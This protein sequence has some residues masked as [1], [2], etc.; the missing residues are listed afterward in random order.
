MHKILY[1]EIIKC[2]VVSIIN[3]LMYYSI[4]SVLFVLLSIAR[5]AAK[6]ATMKVCILLFVL[7]SSAPLKLAIMERNLYP[8]LT[9]QENTRSNICPSN[10]EAIMK[11]NSDINTLISS[12]SDSSSVFDSCKNIPA[13]SPSGYYHLRNSITGDSVLQYCD[14]NR[15]SCCT[16]REGGWMRVANIDMTDPNLCM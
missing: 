11:I 6:K 1:Q 10:T 5:S 9:V 2:V 7:L 3:Y 16:G 8:P 12:I 13:E 4:L 15:T 14:M